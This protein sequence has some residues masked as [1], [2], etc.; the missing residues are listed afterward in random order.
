MT[1]TKLPATKTNKRPNR[2]L[3]F[4]RI[5]ALLATLN[6][7]LVLF[8]L[9]YIPLR[10]FWLQGRV[11]GF[12]KLGNTEWTIPKEPLILPMLPITD[13][14]DWVKG[15]EPNQDTEAYLNQVD[16]LEKAVV[17]KPLQSPEIE[18]ILAN[19]RRQSVEMID[20]NPFQVANK[21]GTLEKVKN[22]MRD[23]VFG[24]EQAS[25]KDAFEQFW[26]LD[27]LNG[28]SYGDEIAFFNRKI[29]P[30]METNYYRPIG[31]NGEPVNNF[32]L[33]DFPFFLIFA[34]E[35]L[36][37]TWFISR[38]RTGV[39][40]LDA[41]TW[42][43]YDVLLL[44]PVFRWLRIIPVVIRL[45]QA[46]LIDLHKIQRQAS[47][48]FVAGIAE[49]VT[50]VVVVNVLNQAQAAIHQGDVAKFLSESTRKTY[51]DLNDINE[52]AEIVKL[53]LQLT[54]N[55]VLPTIKPDLE[56]LLQYSIGKAI[57]DNPAYQGAQVLPGVESLKINLSKQLA[58]GLY[59]A[60]YEGAKGLTQTDPVF[61]E[62]LQRLT[63][64][65]AE[66]LS[67]EMQAQQSL[68]QLEYLLNALIEE[69]KVNYVQRLSE[70][71]IEALLDQTRALRQVKQT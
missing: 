37:R 8:D 14:Y 28:E 26:S 65:L 66:S 27:N 50:E 69:V 62:L 9:T 38:H 23:R 20:T 70:E 63:D 6:Y 13:W 54:V 39:S 35:F 31:E 59:Q 60:L 33:L 19:L 29:R 57:S 44:I 4:E 61:D 56:A 51:I 25:S 55:Q 10:N 64:N 42:R 24:T 43:W 2:N 36:G 47:Q 21:T 5:M 48:G 53:L 49:D 68:D 7:L 30:L 52:T 71:D 11:Q 45:N 58:Q 67:S 46:Q 15:I 17:G 40:W 3:L 12:V 18:A 34:L 22:E 1:L 32:G 41:M 16:T